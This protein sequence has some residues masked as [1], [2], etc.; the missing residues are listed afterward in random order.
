MIIWLSS[1]AWLVKVPVMNHFS[2]RYER[3][4][5][6]VLNSLARAVNGNLVKVMNG[7]MGMFGWL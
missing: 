2:A 1:G 7:Y 5:L 4:W 6:R 3:G